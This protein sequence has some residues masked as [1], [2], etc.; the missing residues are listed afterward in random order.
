MDRI[1]ITAEM[2]ASVSHQLAQPLQVMSTSASIVHSHLESRKPVTNDTYRLLENIEKLAIQSGL[3]VRGLNEFTAHRPRR[4][5]PTD[6]GH[7]V[8]STTEILAAHLRHAETS[9][10]V[11]LPDPVTLAV[12]PIQVRQVLM[13]LIKTSVEA[14]SSRQNSR[15]MNIQVKHADNQVAI[16]LTHNGERIP[17]DQLEQLFLPWTGRLNGRPGIGL[18]ISGRIIKAHNGTISAWNEPE[19]ATFEIVLPE[20]PRT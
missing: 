5:E 12:D 3:A 18:S 20:S 9:V 10:T 16:R 13:N 11:Q 8:H 17:E 15:A 2:A 1:S 14:M 19:G 6:I 7:L 4:P